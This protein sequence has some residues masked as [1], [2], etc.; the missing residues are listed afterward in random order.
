M[1]WLNCLTLCFNII[2]SGLNLAGKYSIGQC[3][4]SELSMQFQ[5]V[6]L[7]GFQN[8]LDGASREFRG[9]VP[10]RQKT[11]RWPTRYTLEII[12]IGKADPNPGSR[13]TFRNC[14]SKLLGF[15]QV[16]SEVLKYFQ[17]PQSPAVV[18]WYLLNS[19]IDSHNQRLFSLFL[20]Q[21][22]G[23]FWWASSWPFSKLSSEWQEDPII[24]QALK[25]ANKR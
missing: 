10:C 11:G 9:P 24:G 17:H 25:K 18:A 5:A 22:F 4:L 2:S 6:F 8:R 7:C 19:I 20:L 14:F 3:Q 13:S 1:P 15:E 16:V 12:W 23:C 21:V